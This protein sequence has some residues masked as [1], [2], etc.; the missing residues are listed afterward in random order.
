MTR[1]KY[2]YAF[3]L[4]SGGGWNA[5]AKNARLYFQDDYDN[6]RIG[7]WCAASHD[8]A[9]SSDGYLQVDLGQQ[10]NITH[11]ATQGLINLF[12]LL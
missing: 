1:L 10:N 6:L 4:L 3:S 7:A 11:I 12:S 2:F 8:S 9:R 5:D